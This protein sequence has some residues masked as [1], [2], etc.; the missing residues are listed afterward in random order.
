MFADLWG[1]AEGIVRVMV[2]AMEPSL[3][4][5]GPTCQATTQLGVRAHS[6]SPRLLSF[7]INR[8]K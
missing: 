2:V 1:A 7:N 3:A 4:S 6:G 5:T 8:I